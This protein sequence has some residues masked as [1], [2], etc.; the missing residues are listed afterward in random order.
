[1]A[2]CVNCVHCQKTMDTTYED[3]E[4]MRYYCC[5]YLD[6]LDIGYFDSMYEKYDCPHEET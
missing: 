6:D 3:R 2:N 1:M 5:K 4:Y